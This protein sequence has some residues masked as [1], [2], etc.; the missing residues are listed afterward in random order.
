MGSVGSSGK[1]DWKKVQLIVPHRCKSAQAF[2]YS[3]MKAL[4]RI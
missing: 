4:S 2:V 1:A 3:K